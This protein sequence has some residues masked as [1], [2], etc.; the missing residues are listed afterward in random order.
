M[1]AHLACIGGTLAYDL[2]REG[3]LVAKRLGAQGTPFGDSQPIY[4]CESRFGEFL[5]LSRH[6]ESGYDL[7]PSFVNYRANIYALK[8]LGVRA[9]V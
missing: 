4:L 8:D 2:L 5:F 7:T 6:G 3:A 9:I 1:N